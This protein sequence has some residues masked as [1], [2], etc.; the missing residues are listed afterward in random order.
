MAAAMGNAGMFR[1][2][3]LSSSTACVQTVFNVFRG[4]SR[5]TIDHWIGREREKHQN[6]SYFNRFS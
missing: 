6:G 3:F 4:S 5:V 1:L 2:F